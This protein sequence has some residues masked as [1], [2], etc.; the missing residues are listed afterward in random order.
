[1]IRI[2]G[3]ISERAK[4]IMQNHPD[5]MD[6]VVSHLVGEKEISQGNLALLDSICKQY[7]KAPVKA[8]QSKKR[9]VITRGPK[10]DGSSFRRQHYFWFFWLT[11]HYEWTSGNYRD[12]DENVEEGKRLGYEI[13]YK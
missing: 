13:I 10:W 7:S 4:Y 3:T 11:V 6:A 8:E 2:E 9:I 5:L 1:M 12:F